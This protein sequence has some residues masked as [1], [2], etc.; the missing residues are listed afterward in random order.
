MSTKTFSCTWTGDPPNW[1]EQPQTPWLPYRPI[2]PQPY[3][4]QPYFTPVPQTGWICPKCGTANSPLKLTC[5]EPPTTVTCL[6]E[7]NGK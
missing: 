5:C 6:T 4:P 1:W 2:T 3:V 7:S